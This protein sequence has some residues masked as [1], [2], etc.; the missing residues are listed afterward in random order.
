[1]IR[2]LVTS[3]ALCCFLIGLIPALADESAPEGSTSPTTSET[4]A[5]IDSLAQANELIGQHQFGSA[6]DLLRRILARTEEKY[7]PDSPEVS[8][9]L[10]PLVMCLWRLGQS[11]TEEAVNLADR[12]IEL[13]NIFYDSN[14]LEVAT[15]LFNRGIMHAMGNDFEA[16]NDIF[17][18][19]LDIR[20]TALPEN[21]PEIASTINALANIKFYKSDFSGALPLYRRSLIMSEEKSGPL[22]PQ[23]LSIRGNLANTLNNLGMYNEARSILEE[24]IEMMESA[25]MIIENLAFAYSLLGTIHAIIGDFEEGLPLRR[26]CLEIREGVHPEGHPRI[27]QALINLGTILWKAGRPEEAKE[28][29]ERGHAIWLET[30]GPENAHIATFHEALG[31][32]AHLQGDLTAAKEHNLRTLEIREKTIGENTPRV[33]Q[34]LKALAL[35]AREE[36][37]FADARSQLQKAIIIMTES[38]GPAGRY[39]AEYRNELS[40]VEYLDG[41]FT[42]ALK[43]ALA[44]E[45]LHTKRLRLAL[46]A[47]PERQALK[48][49][50]Q[51]LVGL[52]LILSL[53]ET[54]AG[55]GSAEQAWDALISSRALVFDEMATRIRRVSHFEN[56][57]FA[58]LFK[59]YQDASRRYANLYVIGPDDAEPTTYLNLLGEARK[60]M[61][62][63]ERELID[64]DTP[65]DFSQINQALGWNDVK[66]KI[67][68]QAAVV[69]FVLYQKYPVG[70]ERNLKPFS[71]YKAFILP[72]D[73]GEPL[74]LDLGEAATIDAQIGRWKRE[75]SLGALSKDRSGQDA[76]QA[77][78][79]VATDL[80]KSIWDPVAT[81][82]EGAETVF[83]IPDGQIH[84]VNFSTLPSQ[85]NI[86]LVES[87]PIFHYLSTEREFTVPRSEEIHSGGALVMGAPDFEGTETTSH[88]AGLQ[89]EAAGSAFR[90]VTPDCGTL[91]SLRFDP[92]P[93]CLQETNEIATLWKS[94]FGTS[95]SSGSQSKVEEIKVLTGREASEGALKRSAPGNRM[96][97]VATHGFFLS[98]DCPSGLEGTRGIGLLVPEDSDQAGETTEPKLVQNP[99]LLSGLALAGANRREQAGADD[100]DGILTAQE[101]ATLDLSS[102]RWATLSACETGTGEV[103]N[104]EGIFGLRRAF[105]I[106]GARTLITSL[107]SVNDEATRLWMSAFYRSGIGRGL[108]AAEAVREADLT[109][110]RERREKNENTHPFFWGGFIASGDWR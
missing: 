81:F 43:E 28:Y 90:G 84:L 62:K 63:A 11:Q 35:V 89:P 76:L 88:L 99:L 46:R 59:D 67:P 31:A 104:G 14:H 66:D 40:L 21:H 39:V 41:N 12:A 92:L 91:K 96:L 37:H 87:G 36:G 94:N 105:R 109:V 60:S 16:A 101:I 86:Y 2:I 100:E 53:L 5:P 52:D 7:G 30:F 48:Y 13:K 82:A 80:R 10:D 103:L 23:T 9:V 93:G 74:C 78:N 6:G 3:F 32:I 95:E 45:N 83:V 106:A 22:D 20:E 19:V 8:R 17:T 75:I 56:P 54:D 55:E 97:H 29:I 64:Q 18:R 26:R 79:V 107:W 57:E 73:H 85:D 25:D 47:L 71:A 24:H 102:V 65:F 77:Y 50:Q 44:T 61:E 33:A 4:T 69:A 38:M 72:A 110:L 58:A 98:A 27:A 1:M 42:A 15:S 70:S 49:A 68:D 34:A 51:S 108:G